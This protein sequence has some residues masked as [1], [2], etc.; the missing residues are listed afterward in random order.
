MSWAHILLELG[1]LISGC[2]G[3]VPVEAGVGRRPIAVARV[4]AAGLDRRLIAATRIVERAG[5][6]VEAVLDRRPIAVARGVEAGL[7]R[8]LIVAA[9][10]A[11]HAGVEAGH[12]EQVGVEHVAETA[13][14][15]VLRGVV[16][17]GAGPV[18][19]QV[20]AV[21]DQHAG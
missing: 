6:D 16:S 17:T 18:V 12:H 7:D 20:E 8:R 1:Y 21:L 15:Q 5:V 19:E 9:G 10:I 4:V 3:T 13:P 2:I 11:E 14:E